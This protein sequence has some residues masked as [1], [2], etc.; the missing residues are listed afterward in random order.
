MKSVKY[1]HIDHLNGSGRRNIEQGHAD[2]YR[3]V[4]D[5]I[6]KLSE[7]VPHGRD[8]QNASN[9]EFLEARTVWREQVEALVAVRDAIL[10]SVV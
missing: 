4:D 8:W 9:E 5:A 2:T 1:P 10:E 6:R 3:A 7:I